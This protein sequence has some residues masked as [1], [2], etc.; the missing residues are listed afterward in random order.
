MACLVNGLAR[1]ARTT[2]YILDGRNMVEKY[3][4]EATCNTSDE[5][6]ERQK[7]TA[8]RLTHEVFPYLWLKKVMAERL[9]C[10]DDIYSIRKAIILLDYMARHG[11]AKVRDDIIEMQTEIEM[12]TCSSIFPGD[13]RGSIEVESRKRAT[14]LLVLLNDDDTY[15][16]A[17][18]DTKKKRCEIRNLRLELDRVSSS[19][20]RKKCVSRRS[21]GSLEEEKVSIDVDQLELDDDL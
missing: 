13:A 7:V 12:V 9:A 5:L 21:Y 3:F 4:L 19:P 11:D 2:N 15:E 20:E 8:A 10:L 14:D 16:K 6:T 1:I 18:G 17:R